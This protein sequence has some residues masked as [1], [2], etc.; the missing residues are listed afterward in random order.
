MAANANES[1][2]YNVAAATLYA[3]LNSVQFSSELRIELKSENFMTGGRWYRFHHGTTFSSWG[4]KITITVNEISPVCTRVDIR[5][6]CGMPT[7]IVDWGKNRQNI[8][9]IFAYFD[10]YLLASQFSV[11][12][13]SYTQPQIQEEQSFAQ[14]QMQPQTQYFANTDTGVR[15][16][17]G[18]GTKISAEDRFCYRCGHPAQ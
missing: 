2:T 16:C 15:F 7:Q 3:T 8:A 12:D 1:R 11:T 10:R 5:S 9:A 6:E 18:C 13:F 4:E 14:P 17:T